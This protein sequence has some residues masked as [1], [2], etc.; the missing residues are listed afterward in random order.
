MAIDMDIVNAAMVRHRSP[1]ELAAANAANALNKTEL[2][3][4]DFLT[5][6]ITQLKNQDPMKPLDGTAFIAQLAQFGAV[7]GIQE[8][9]TSMETL[10]ASLRSTQALNGASLVGREILAPTD[11]ITHTEGVSVSGEVEVP[12]GVSTVEIRITDSAGEVVRQ[13]TV[14]ATDD[15]ARFTW[16]GLRDNGAAAGSGD[17]AIEAIGRIGAESESLNVLMSGRVSSVSIDANGAG[18]TLNTGALGP[19]SMADV[20]RVM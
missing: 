17:Y 14:P 18:L 16:D 12:E 7:S 5:L 2:G 19:I 1:D 13:M 3:Q 4:D 8:M 20:R 11:S 15:I 9:Q 6:M 10:A